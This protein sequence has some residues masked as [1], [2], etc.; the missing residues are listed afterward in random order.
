LAGKVATS[1][2]R[3]SPPEQQF[4]AR[5]VDELMPLATTADAAPGSRC[6]NMESRQRIHRPEEQ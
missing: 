6:S 3:A 4:R 5:D 1:S 2:R